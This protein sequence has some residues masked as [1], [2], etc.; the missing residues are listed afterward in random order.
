MSV[1]FHPII[2]SWALSWERIQKKTS[3]NTTKKIVHNKNLAQPPCPRI[4]S[5][6]TIQWNVMLLLREI[7]IINTQKH[8]KPSL[9]NVN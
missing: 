6:I 2:P 8:K 4:V 1:P 3:N 7:H 5:G 9:N